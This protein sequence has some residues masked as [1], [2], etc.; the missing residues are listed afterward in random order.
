MFEDLRAR[1][2]KMT[3]AADGMDA[4]LKDVKSRLDTLIANGGLSDADKAELQAISDGID[5][6]AD[7]IVAD[8]LANTPAAS[9]APAP[10]D[11]GTGTTDQA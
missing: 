3:N 10:V 6:E 5:K 7:L 2:Q 11:Q 8:T 9:Q 4:T 1:V